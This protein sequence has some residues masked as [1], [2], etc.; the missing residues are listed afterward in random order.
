MLFFDVEIDHLQ[1]TSGYDIVLIGSLYGQPAFAKAYGSFDVA[2]NS[3][4]LS[5]GWQA[6]L[7]NGASVGTIIGAFLNGY[8]TQKYGYRQVMML[9]LAVMIGC[10]FFPFFAPNLAVLLVGQICCGVP[11]GV[12]ATMAPAY[13]SEICPTALRAYLTVY[14]NLTWAFGQL[15]AAGVMS[16]FRD[17][18]TKWAYK[19][20]F[21]IQWIWPLPIMILVYFAPESPW[22]LVRLGRLD[23]AKKVIARISSNN[24]SEDHEKALAM[25]VR[26]NKM[27]IEIETGTSYFDCLKRSDLRRTEIMC[28][29]C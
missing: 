18:T 11:W 14:V 10:I 21:A 13:A 24:D 20:P 5:A 9:S 23:E 8:M 12:F 7:S 15:V 27:E 2:T 4:S 22:H 1:A 19:I 6:A 28:M 26:T 3:Y 25:L 17:G 16:G 29:V